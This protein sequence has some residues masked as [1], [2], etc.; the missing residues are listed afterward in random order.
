MNLTHNKHPEGERERERK[1]KRLTGVSYIPIHI[2]QP[3]IKGLKHMF[4]CTGG[5]RV[6]RKRR[7]MLETGQYPSRYCGRDEWD[8][9]DPKDPYKEN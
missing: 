7:L 6:A 4:D 1:R 2:G 9:E 5:T 8:E 3:F